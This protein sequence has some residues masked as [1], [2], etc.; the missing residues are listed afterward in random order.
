[1]KDS[2]NPHKEPVGSVQLQEFDRVAPQG[3]E[4]PKA[5]A[6][7]KRSVYAA[8]ETYSNVHRGSGHGSLV[9]TRLYEQARDIVL[10]HLRLNKDRYVVVF[11]SP[12]SAELLKGELAP[13][14]FQCVSSQDIGLPLGITAVA[15]ERRALPGGAPYQTGGGTARLIAPKWVIWAK[16]P[17]RL[18][19]GTPAIV[20]VIAFARALQLIRAFGQS[21]FH[22]TGAD[23]LAATD[24]LYRDE[25]EQYAGRALLDELRR[26][27]IGRDVR[28]P[29]VAGASPYINLDNGASTRTFTPIWDAVWQTWRQPRQVQQA[30][31]NEVK[32]ICADLLGAPLSVYDVIFASNTTEAINMVADSLR[33]ESDQSDESVVLNTLLEHNSN[34]LVWRMI[35]GV[36]LIRLPVDETGV[37]DLA[38]LDARLR[39]YNQEGE[40]GKKRIKLV[41]VSGASN[42]LGVYNDLAAVSRIVHM[43]GARLLVDAA[44]LVAHRAVDM[45][46]CDIDYLAF[47]AHKAYAPFGSGALVARK[48]LLNLNPAEMALIKSSGEE[49]AGGIAALGKAFVLLQRIGLDVIQEE[50]QALTARALRG[51]AQISSL[52]LYGIKESGSPKFAQKGGVIPFNMKGMVSERVSR[53]L[54][55]RGGIGIRHGCHCAHL[56]VKRILHIPPALELF[57]GLIVSLIPRLE[58]P[59]VA[60]VSLGLENSIED[61]DT[62][63]AVL[64]TIAREAEARASN[65]GAASPAAKPTLA[66]AN[67]QQQ[68]DAFAAAASQRVYG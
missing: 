38:E 10:E 34:E 37:M 9:T 30:I 15:I 14:R 47:S 65:H 36:A 26:T 45:E 40:H 23:A 22:E 20:N 24:I 58:L 56:L 29:T 6:E 59:G 8:L 12:R 33:S 32:S 3:N 53:E 46:L 18:E 42:V 16:S 51:M 52:T 19:P 25:L 44:Q 48:G 66:Q 49:N 2:A 67:L 21:A 13:G 64:G 61:V 62:L 4:L 5:F 35:P 1:M 50:E 55:E 27:L 41:A 28:V 11:V 31:I 63:I 68:I 57:Q 17:A 7:L 43:H 54:A 39:A 60:R